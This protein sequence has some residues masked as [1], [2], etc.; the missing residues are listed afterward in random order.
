[1][2]FAQILALI[3]TFGVY[4]WASELKVEIEKPQTNF[5]VGGLMSISILVQNLG[6]VPVSLPMASAELPA[7]HLTIA[8]AGQVAQIDAWPLDEGWSSL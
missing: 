4:G 1:M 8:R 3:I 7:W 6:E 2:K 5:T